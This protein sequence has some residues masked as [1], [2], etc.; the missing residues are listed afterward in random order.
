MMRASST[1][2]IIISRKLSWNAFRMSA[3]R[4]SAVS[5]RRTNLA[6]VSTWKKERSLSTL[7]GGRRT[8]DGQ[9]PFPP[10]LR[11]PLA[12]ATADRRRRRYQYQP[13]LRLPLDAA[14]VSSTPFIMFKDMV[15]K[16]VLELKKLWANKRQLT[17]QLLNLAMI[18]F[19]A[20]MIWKGLMFA[21]RVRRLLFNVFVTISVNNV[22]VHLLQSIIEY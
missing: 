14:A 13:P 12:T 11:Q 18:V 5:V 19:S 8:A 9:P 21:T 10:P 7:S 2:S 1:K 16:Q 20:L 17:F 3:C 6:N 15:N 22:G 4:L